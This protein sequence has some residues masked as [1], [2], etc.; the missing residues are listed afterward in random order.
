MATGRTW[1]TLERIANVIGIL[2]AAA[3]LG[4]IGYFVSLGLQLVMPGAS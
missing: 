3:A 2:A 4:L 1:R